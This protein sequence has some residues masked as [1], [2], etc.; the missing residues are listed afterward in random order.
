MFTYDF[1][2]AGQGLFTRGELQFYDRGT[3]KRRFQWVYDCG[4]ENTRPL[5]GQVDLY[6]RQLPEP[7]RL[8]LLVLSH[9]DRDH[10]RG[11]GRLLN[12]LPV[13]H[14]VLPYVTPGQWM[15]LALASG[16]DD[17]DWLRFLVNP[18]A[19]LTALPGA[20]I[21]SVVVVLPSDDPIA[22]PEEPPAES[23]GPNTPPAVF[24]DLSPPA[25]DVFVDDPDLILE[26]AAG[27]V[28][29]TAAQRPVEVLGLWE[30]AFFNRPRPEMEPRLGSRIQPL[31]DEFY[32]RTERDRDYVG[33][34]RQLRGAYEGVFGATAAG[35]NEI[36]LVTYT[37][38]VSTRLH[39]ASYRSR[40]HGHYPASG[41]SRSPA[42]GASQ[43]A[44]GGKV[45]LLYTGDITCDRATTAQ[46]DHRFSSQRLPRLRFLQVPHHGS[47]HSWEVGQ[48]ALW[49]HEWSVI[50]AGLNNSHGHPAPEVIEE[51]SARG[52]VVVNE[53]QGAAWGGRVAWRVK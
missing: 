2:P 14:L 24:P 26:G 51:L 53:L 19:Y 39:A 47:R 16:P 44:E 41:E 21:G 49:P 6:R 35:R 31:F 25:K 10:L 28:Q 30:F 9:F 33:F 18:V 52:P 11:L 5:H 42:F 17:P 32:R 43:D 34:V 7:K 4:S 50:S 27:H 36:S 40:D 3:D 23:P 29:T 37:G 1:R 12:S 13:S 45:S 20:Q 46:F 15:L 22:P 38:P 8:D 48:A